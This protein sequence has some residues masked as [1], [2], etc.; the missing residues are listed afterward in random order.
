[1]KAKPCQCPWVTSSEVYTN[2]MIVTI[3]LSYA[4]R[5]NTKDNNSREA[6]AVVCYLVEVLSCLNEE[7]RVV[8]VVVF[9]F[10]FEWHRGGKRQRGGSTD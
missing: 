10:R 8:R 3:D 1:M 5:F 7:T 6:N 9:V 2:E 4:A